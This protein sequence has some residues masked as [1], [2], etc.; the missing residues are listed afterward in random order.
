MPT[1]NELRRIAE[2]FGQ[3][4][5]RYDRTRPR[6]PE[7]MVE[8][9]VAALPSPKS[10]LD[11]GVGT[12]IAARQFQAAGCRV[13]GVDPDERMA[14]LARTHGIEVEVSAFETWDPKRR[15]FDAVIAGQ[16]WHWVDPLA[17]AQQAARVLRPGG[18]IA[19]F[20]NALAPS[21]EV[22]ARFGEVYRR[23]APSLPFNPWAVPKNTG[24]G[25]HDRA[26]DGLRESKAFSEPVLWNF[27]WEHTYTREA[28]LDMVPT[29]GGHNLLPPGELQA[30]LDGL[31]AA[32][33]GTVTIDYTTVVTTASTANP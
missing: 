4:A 17:G 1:P 15:R 32:L 28:W 29:A 14:A 12:G 25:F 10:V 16:T 30:L 33:D 31:A 9:I 23:V 19:L 11:V 18:M 26:A 20:W 3:D 2:S 5:E 7:P 6:Y 13:L 24:T 21:P 8:R 22:A 27:D